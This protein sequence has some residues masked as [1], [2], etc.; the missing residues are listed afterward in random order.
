MLVSYIITC[1]ILHLVEE[2]ICPLCTRI[3]AIKGEKWAWLRH[4]WRI[5]GM[6]SWVSFTPWKLALRW[7]SI[8]Q[9]RCRACLRYVTHRSDL[10]PDRS[11][12]N[13]ILHGL[14]TDRFSRSYTTRVHLSFRDNASIFC[15]Y[16]WL[17]HRNHW[18]SSRIR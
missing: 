6:Q 11:F 15:R 18:I 9:V 7:L 3:H 14:A 5:Q 13:C 8:L 1:N 12:S 10:I 4:A 16:I 17:F 2:M